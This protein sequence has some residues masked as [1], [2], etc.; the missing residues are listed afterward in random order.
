MAQTTT[1]KT[2]NVYQLGQELSG[3]ALRVTGP[4]NGVT[5]VDADTTQPALE[6]AVAAHTANPAIQPPT[7]P[8]V[9]VN[10]QDVLDKTSL[11][12]QILNRE[13]KARAVIAD[14]VNATDWT[15]NERKVAIAC[16]VLFLCK[17]LR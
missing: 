3:V 9:A 17:E 4:D 5:K 6:A 13:A 14:P 10:A 1:T 11:R 7:D 12:N 15:A 16:L 8:S 2:I